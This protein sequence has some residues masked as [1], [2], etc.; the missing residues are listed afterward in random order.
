MLKNF[1]EMTKNASKAKVEYVDK[2]SIQYKFNSL[3]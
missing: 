3:L 1:K 2:M